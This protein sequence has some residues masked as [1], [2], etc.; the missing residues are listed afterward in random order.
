M[1]LS[2]QGITTVTATINNISS[3]KSPVPGLAQDDF[4]VPYCN[5][6]NLPSECNSTTNCNCPHMIELKLNRTYD[7]IFRDGDGECGSFSCFH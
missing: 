3:T 2:E 7:L 1:I 5:A 4:Y 6:A